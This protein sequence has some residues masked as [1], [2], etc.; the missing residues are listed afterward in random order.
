MANIRF[1]PVNTT[2]ST[3]NSS[4][5]F[6]PVKTISTP[7]ITAK[8]KTSIGKSVLN[9]GFLLGKGIIKGAENISDAIVNSVF[10]ENNPILQLATGK[11]AKEKYIGAISAV[12]NN[13]IPKNLKTG[14]NTISSL[15]KKA[16]I[17]LPTIG[18]APKNEKI[19]YLQKGASQVIAE[20]RTQKLLN[21]LGY[22]KNINGNTTLQDWI[23]KNSAIKEN[24]LAGQVTTSIGQMLPSVVLGNTAGSQAVGYGTLGLGSYGSGVEQ[25]YQNNAT[26]EQAQNYGKLNALTEV[27]TEMLTGGI[28]GLKIKG[29]SGLDSLAEKGIG[30]VSNKLAQSLLN[31]GYKIVGEGGEEALSQYIQPFIQNATYTKDQKVNWND[32]LNSAIV[33]GITGGIL[34]A[35]ININNLNTAIK[36]QKATKSNLT[37]QNQTNVLD[38]VINQ[39]NIKQQKNGQINFPQKIIQSSLDADTKFVLN[40]I[41]NV[42]KARQGLDFYRNM[43]NL[44]NQDTANKVT[45]EFDQAKL[46]NVNLNNELASDLKKNIVDKYNIQKGSK[47]SALIQ[48][49]GEGLISLEQLKSQSPKNWQNI[50]EADK[51]FRKQY[52]TLIDKI[53]ESRKKIYP[54]VE[55]TIQEYENNVEEIGKKIVSKQAELKATNK[56]TTK[57]DNIRNQINNLNLRRKSYIDMLES[58]EILKNKRVEKRQDYYRHFQEMAEGFKA[59]GNILTTSSDISPKMVGISEFTKP[60]AKFSSITQQ[61]K[62]NKT[63]YDAIGGFLNYIPTASYMINIDPQIYKLRKMTSDLREQMGGDTSANKAIQFLTDFTNKL[64][65]KTTGIDREIQKYVPGGRTALK[66]VDW[67]NG[68]IKSNMIL[69]NVNSAISQ[70]LNLPQVVGKVKNPVLLTK[71]FIDTFNAKTDYSQ[72]Q[73]ITER[74]KSDILSQFDN[75]MIDQPKKLAKWMLEALDEKVTKTGWNALYQDAINKNIENPV[76]YADNNIRDLVAGRGIGEKTLLQESKTFNLIAPFTVEVGNLMRVMG[77]FAKQKD[78]AGL[79]ILFV[80][81]NLLNKGIKKIGASGKT[82]DPIEAVKDA[83]SEED[84]SIFER[85]GRVGGEVL[86]NVP[87]GQ[88][89]ATL[90]PEYGSDTMPS[91]KQL[92]GDNDPTRYGTGSVY[93]KVFTKPLTSVVT[94]YGGSQLEKIKKGYDIISKGGE[95]KKGKLKYPVDKNFANT[96]RALAFG[97]T[98]ETQEFYDKKRAALSKN[99]T[100]QVE[101]SPDI[102]KAYESIMKV[103]EYKALQKKYEEKINKATGEEKTRLYKEFQKK[104]N[105]LYKK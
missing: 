42:K 85:L 90:Y 92:F 6:T 10:S 36:E 88:Q 74:Y 21:D 58:D 15:A 61:R 37:P 54:N 96:V 103:R 7:K 20:D 11:D 22:N 81:A 101:A 5:R 35:P 52:D 40:D 80:M 87:L 65:G 57:Y 33:G 68:R 12:A 86:S 56:N 67:L 69:G 55:K 75:K 23:G 39:E 26:R 97:S 48:K 84:L 105:E 59:L 29:L 45:G 76:Q 14:V 47:D 31:A 63:T 62:T 53:N 43:R 83:L 66:G 13:L 72:S 100:K 38:N 82:F 71:G 70:V 60:N 50:V 8:E 18:N 78:I 17:N 64:A 95:Y 73:F 27:G 19:K 4:A 28:P 24:N 25:A 41:K 99:Q 1:T 44:F 34:E 46:S 77:D 49:Y 51:Y 91:R 79:I 9:T 98:K 30:K 94:P 93:S 89:I 16:N 2:T 102:K 104:L 3:N 32:V